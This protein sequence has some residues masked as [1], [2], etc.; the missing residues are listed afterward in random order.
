MRT[1]FEPQHF[2]SSD[3]LPPEI[4]FLQG[5]FE[6]DV[7]KA[8]AKRAHEQ[9]VS[10]ETVLLSQ[11]LMTEG[12]YYKALA[13]AV[14]CPFEPEGWNQF[15]RAFLARAVFDGTVPHT[16]VPLSGQDKTLSLFA[17]A[18]IGAHIGRL[19]LLSERTP[20]ATKRLVITTPKNLMKA[21]QDTLKAAS[22]ARASNYLKFSNPQLSAASKQ[23]RVQ[24]ITSLV[25]LI[26]GFALLVF[27]PIWFFAL[28][29]SLFSLIF[30]AHSLLKLLSLKS[31]PE[32]PSIATLED[33][34][35]PRYAILVPL[36]KEGKGVI[37]QLREALLALDYPRAKLSIY[38]IT[39]EDD[40]E[41]HKALSAY[42]WPREFDFVVVPA[43]QPRTKPK[44]MNVA[45]SYVNTPYLTIYDAEDIPEPDQLRKAAA[46][47]AAKPDIACLQ[48]RLSFFNA[49]TNWL[50]AQFAIEYASLF[51]HIL[52]AFERLGLPL[53]LGGTSNHF[54]VSALKAA[55]AWDPYNVTEDADLGVRL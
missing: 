51:D 45:L 30:A 14:G 32:K 2:S 6:S 21:L 16:I 54:R 9:G 26:A 55:G 43:G 19:L 13:K 50:T 20:E 39:E 5:T 10:A 48:A 4:A 31:P 1:I 36:Y 27:Q 44:A 46:H 22:H 41:T 53:P 18:P 37:G 23:P 17:V 24:E 11:G 40:P 3:Q 34:A 33:A 52:P 47:F 15:D 29:A 42:H 35:L 49:Q 25:M 7:L 12:G 8:L 38:L 28:L